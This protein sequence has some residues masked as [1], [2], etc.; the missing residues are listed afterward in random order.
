MKALGTLLHVLGQLVFAVAGLWGFVLCLGIIFHAAGFWG[1]VVGLLL[2]PITFIAAPF[3]A[4]FEQGNWFPLL[5]NYGA[6]LVGGV[7]SLVG[8]SMKER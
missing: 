4:G 5:L 2:G 6:V 1:V 8:I 7:L 3:Y